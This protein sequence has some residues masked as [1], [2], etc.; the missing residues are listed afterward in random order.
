MDDRPTPPEIEKEQLT[1]YVRSLLIFICVA[2]FFE[3]YDVIIINLTLPYLGKEFLVDS[4]T[5][6]FAVSII[7]I[8]TIA[9]FL[10]V[11]L[12]DRY[13]RRPVLLT[14]VAGYTLFTVATAFST[15]IYSFVALQ[16]IARMFMVAEVGI[17]AII[18]TEEMPARFRGRA[19]SLMLGAGFLGGVLASVGFPYLIKTSLSWRMLYL[20]GG[21]LLPL[22]IVYRNRLQE[23]RRWLEQYQ[24]G[25]DQSRSFIQVMR[26]TKVIFERRYRRALITGTSIW[27]LTNFWSSAALFFFTYYVMQERGWSPELVG[28]V[29]PIAA[30]FSVGAF[31]I[32]GPLLDIVG[33][34]VTAGLFFSMAGISSIVCFQAETTLVIAIAYIFVMA[35]NAVWAISATVT[36]EIFPTAVRA[37]GNSVVN[38]LL[39]R[40]GM[41]IG[42]ALVGVLSKNLGS[43]GDAVAVLAVFNFL[44]LPIILFFLRETRGQVLEDISA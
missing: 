23:T 15:D 40:T 42:P 8:G 31:L 2:S 13:G 1:P 22:L 41:V 33:R 19:I 39:G 7:S 9:A 34:R 30:L 24:Q 44:L 37:T 10:P 28:K 27:F 3:A 43:V 17:G 36:S 12:A 38:N 6:G 25:K 18:L 5:L 26:D 14:V 11:R 4:Q 32:V 35:S 16:F 29:V 20:V 21:L